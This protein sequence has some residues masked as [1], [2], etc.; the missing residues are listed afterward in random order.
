MAEE[1]LCLLSLRSQVDERTRRALPR[2]P[3]RGAGERASVQYEARWMFALREANMP[4]DYA[5]RHAL[6]LHGE[7]DAFD[8][9]LPPP[10]IN[11]C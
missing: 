9:L 6:R 4:L 5:V 10:T 3:F 8:L 7:V 11:K 1:C 2:S